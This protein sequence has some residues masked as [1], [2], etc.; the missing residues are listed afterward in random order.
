[1]KDKKRKRVGIFGGSF[2][3]IHNGH[4]NM[5]KLAV[6]KLGLDILYIVPVG[7]PCH[8]PHK[9]FATGIE[10]LE[11]VDLTCKNED[12]L[13]PCDLE[14]SSNKISYTYDTLLKI[15]ERHP[16]ADIFEILGEDSAEYLHKW[17]N[18]ELMRK[19]CTF[20]YFKRDG[21]LSKNTELLPIE[22]P[23]FNV[24]STLIR[25]KIKNGESLKELVSEEVED[26]I[27]RNKL[28]K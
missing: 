8:R 20:A 27:Y 19:M 11:M 7:T 4:L 3:P 25:E 10:R 28:Y 23:L 17:K 9:E 15:K 21:H 24:S 16:N 18:Y 2:N 26:Y 6:E 14:V 13:L 12:K 1:M 5:A 22:S